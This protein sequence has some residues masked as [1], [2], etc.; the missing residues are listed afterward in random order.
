MPV[1]LLIAGGAQALGGIVGGI[2]GFSQRR[3][4]RNMLRDIGNQPMYQIPDEILRNQRMAELTAQQ[5][6]PSQQYNNAMKNI[7][8]NQAAL[9][10][11]SMDR[12]SAL[13]ALPKLQQQTNDAYGNL[14]AQDAMQKLKNQQVLYNVGNTTAQYKTKAFDINQMQPWLRNYDYAMRL[15]GAG[16]QNIMGGLDKL[17][18]G[19]GTAMGGNLGGAMGG[20]GGL[21]GSGSGANAG[22]YYNPTYYNGATADTSNSGFETGY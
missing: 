17:V 16:N 22:K 18:G 5:G 4:A 19:I 13:M 21:L 11:G 9:L 6:L 7:Q 14:D 3:Q 1:P 15:K 20:F 12:R 8:R 2:E 10:A